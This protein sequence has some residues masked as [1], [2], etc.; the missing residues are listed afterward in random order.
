[1]EAFLYI[2]WEKLR[3]EP[4]HYCSMLLSDS[5]GIIL[6][7]F[8][9]GSKRIRLS[10]NRLSHP[11]PNWMLAKKTL[12]ATTE[13][14]RKHKKNCQVT[15]RGRKAVKHISKFKKLTINSYLLLST[16]TVIFLQTMNII[17]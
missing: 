11:N 6:N 14:K 2:H 7:E 4:L 5:L 3:I 12:L 16:R 8:T 9:I 15:I 1:M 17:L 10:F 13:I